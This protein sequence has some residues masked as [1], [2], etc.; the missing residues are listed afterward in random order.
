M[1]NSSRSYTVGFGRE[2]STKAYHLRNSIWWWQ[3]YNTRS[4]PFLGVG[5][6]CHHATASSS[7][8]L[9][10][11]ISIEIPTAGTLKL[12]DSPTGIHQSPDALL[13]TCR[14]M[15]RLCWGSQRVKP[16]R[17]RRHL[18]GTG[19]MPPIGHLTPVA[20]RHYRKCCLGPQQE[21]CDYQLGPE[22]AG[23]V[24]L[25]LMM[26]HVC[27]PLTEKQ[28]ALFS[29]NSPT[30][31]WVQRMA[32]CSSLVAEQLVQVLALCFNIQRVCPITTLH[33][34]G[35]QNSMTHIPS[36]SFGSEP[37]W[38]FK[39]ESDLLTFFNCTFTLPKQNLWTVC[40]PISTIATRV[41]SILRMT[42]FTLDDWRRLPVAGRN[43]GPTGKSMCCLWE[44][45]LTFRIPPS[46]SA[47]NSYQALRHK[48]EQ[49]T[50]VTDVKSK[51]ARSVVRFRPL[52]R[53]LLWPVMPTLPR[54]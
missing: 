3:S 14:G 7:Y 24:I 21:G 39:L 4:L 11:S 46:P 51:V 10:W 38:H 37:K 43:I 31:S 49:A 18:R 47:S 50:M 12:P 9:Q 1:Q 25:W 42:P 26:E 45:T 54:S 33:I 36:R 41:I 8:T 20:A 40:Q 15:A 16:R 19:S 27:R 28:I 30:V 48:S 44:W 17:G 6:S 35:D 5:D 13:R 32:S 29:D 2:T 23:L 34:V 52:A 53:R 22:L